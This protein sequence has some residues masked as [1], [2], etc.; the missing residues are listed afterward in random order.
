MGSNPVWRIDLQTR[1]RVSAKEA[2]G[3]EGTF[4][5]HSV[6]IPPGA[7]MD[8][9]PSRTKQL[10]GRADGVERTQLLLRASSEVRQVPRREPR[11]T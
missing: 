8:G 1:F 6:R 9:V 10:W 3:P 5:S 11:D 7:A 2:E 4:N